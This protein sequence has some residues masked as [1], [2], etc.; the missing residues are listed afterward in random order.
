MIEHEIDEI[1][2]GG[3]QG[4]TLNSVYSG[5]AFAGFVGPLD[6][7]RYT[8]G[9]NSPSFTTSSSANACLSVNGG[10]TDIV[11]FNQDYQ[12]DYGDFDY[13]SSGCPNCEFPT[14]SS[15]PDYVQEAFS[16]SDQAANETTSSPEYQMMES[17]GYDPV[18]EPASAV[19]LSLGIG[20][21]AVV[22]RRRRPRR[23]K[24]PANPIA[25]QS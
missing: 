2:G 12:G 23:M 9:S 10:L 25:A 14:T 11:Q 4:S 7:Y 21:I 5:D 18:P 19:L 16:C 24:M 6:L 20:G 8:C 15:C 3:G 22:R 13:D 1:L 17:I